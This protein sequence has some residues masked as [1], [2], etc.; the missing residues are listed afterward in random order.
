[1]LN[2]LEMILG[3]FR[4]QFSRERTFKWFVI[5]VVGFMLRTDQ[6]G[7]TSILRDLCLPAVCYEPLIHFFRSSSY[8][9]TNLRAQWYAI[10]RDQAPLTV[11]Q[12]RNILIGDGV[13]QSKEAFQMPAVKK[14]RQ[15]SETCSKPEY[16]HGH[17]LGGL[18]VLIGNARKHF[19]LPL[20]MNIQDG[21]KEAADWPEAEG[22]IDISSASHVVQMIENSFEISDII[23]KSW[24]VLDRYFLTV[25]ALMRCNELNTERA[26]RGCP[27]QIEIITKAKRNCKVYMR[28]LPTPPGKRGRKRKHG[29]E[30]KLI[31]LFDN[32]QR[33]QKHHVMLYGKET[34]V[35]YY[36]IDLLWGQK[37]YQKLRFVL[38][39]YNGMKSI[40]VST[41]TTLSP[42]KII[43]LYGVR[44]STES[45]F[46]E[47]KQQIGGFMYHFWTMSITKL[48]HFARKSDPSPM[49]Q[50]VTSGERLHIVICLHAIESFVFCATVAMG[51]LQLTAL[52]PGLQKTILS[53][54]YLRT[55]SNEVPSEAS[56]IYFWRR[57]IFLVLH[58]NPKSFITQ[59]ILEKQNLQN[60]DGYTS[61]G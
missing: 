6:L 55:Q 28:P 37:L 29:K 26:K 59:I 38:V 54:R 19:C 22:I 36:T 50:A 12:G 3:A 31:T 48:N 42:L 14:I 13:K 35:E 39:E 8:S 56:V 9:L 53:A 10:V 58:K 5:C 20:K 2:T 32:R 24:L 15:E 47:F 60:E 1:M 61:A 11:V 25:P 16:I 41:D 23:G 46:R 4:K 17:L 44:F 45:L 7:V 30:I 57:Q 49:Q 34:E 43:E 51:I 18:G 33:F 27:H 40:L 21:I 52:D